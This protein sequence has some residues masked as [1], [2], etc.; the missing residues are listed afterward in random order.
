MPCYKP[1][2]AVPYCISQETG[3]VQYKFREKLHDSGQLGEVVQ[4]KDGKYY[5]IKSLPCGK[6]IGCRLDYSREWAIRCTLEMQDFDPEQCWFVTLTYDDF[7]VPTS[8]YCLLGKDYWYKQGITVHNGI[9][10][11]LYGY[12]LP[13]DDLSGLS[14]PLGVSLTLRPK[15]LQDFI[16][17]LRWYVSD[18]YGQQVR[19]YACGEYGSKTA[20]PHYHLIIYGLPL[21]PFGAD[22]WQSVKNGNTVHECAELEK[23]WKQGNVIVGRCTYESCGYVARYMLKKK[24]GHYLEFYQSFNLV[25]E[26][27]RMSLK[28]GIGQRYY[29]AHAREIYDND[30][31]YL[32]TE[33]RGIKCKPP[34]YFDIRAADE[35]PAVFENLKDE[36]SDASIFAMMAKEAVA[37]LPI[38]EILRAQEES[39]KFK[40]KVLQER[41]AT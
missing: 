40:T 3:K 17:R 15:H 9:A 39:R 6:C 13:L 33:K 20:R 22:A 1:M 5:P 4:L 27:T 10:Y 28:P 11:D 7:H 41:S 35:F 12:E 18:R 31:I 8:R 23:I 38:A 34:R 26:F 29:D 25:P 16:K 14:S 37:G 24:K 36:R 21:Q 19:F 30:E 32:E 2:L